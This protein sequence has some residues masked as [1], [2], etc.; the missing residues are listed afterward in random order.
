MAAHERFGSFLIV[1]GSTLGL[2]AVGAALPAVVLVAIGSI[3]G[4]PESLRDPFMGGV[5]IF[6]GGVLL[7]GIG[8]AIGLW[9]SLVWALESAA[10]QRKEDGDLWS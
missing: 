1:L 9:S 6:F 10:R 5:V 8:M 7:G 2:G 4:L 3:V